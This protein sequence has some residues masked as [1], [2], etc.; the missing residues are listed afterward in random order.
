MTRHTVTD[1]GNGRK[2]WTQTPNIVFDLG[3]RPF[4]LALY[5]QLK[6]IAGQ[7]GQCDETTRQL[8]ARMSCSPMAISKALEELSLRRS[9]L[10]GKALVKVAKVADGNGSRYART[11]VTLT[12]IWPENMARY[13]GAA[14]NTVDG[15]VNNMDGAVNTVD[16]GR[17]HSVHPKEQEKNKEQNTPAANGTRRSPHPSEPS[18]PTPPRPA[19]SWAPF[20]AAISETMG[21]VRV[22]N[23]KTGAP[24]AWV[25][26]LARI[27][28]AHVNGIG[29][30][31]AA[32]LWREFV[33]S[34]DWT[35]AGASPQRFPAAFGKWVGKRAGA[36]GKPKLYAHVGVKWGDK[37]P[38]GELPF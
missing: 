1:D 3:L 7:D 36:G 34:K 11:V 38:D 21:G 13:G 22:V 15:A 4:P 9:E 26:E 25:G 16:G 19:P 14:V 30:A 5:G 33:A 17:K 8:A 37:V 12:D 23:A 32:D 29:P 27:A 6:R 31:G 35:Y 2:Y 10:M 24:L 28:G 20:Y 18:D